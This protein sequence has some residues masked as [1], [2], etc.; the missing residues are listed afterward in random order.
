MICFRY[1]IVNALHKS[2]NKDG[3][4]GGGGG[5]GGGGD[6]GDDDDDD[7]MPTQHQFSKVTDS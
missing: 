7:K 6:D 3:D 1:I 2:D 5:G 4:G